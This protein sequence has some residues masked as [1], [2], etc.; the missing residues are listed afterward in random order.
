MARRLLVLTTAL[1]LTGGCGLATVETTSDTEAGKVGIDPTPATD[2]ASPETTSSTS[3]APSLPADLGESVPDDTGAEAPV[4]TTVQ[5]ALSGSTTVGPGEPTTTGAA[6]PSTV[7]PSTTTTIAPSTTSI[8]PSTTTTIALEYHDVGHVVFAYADD[9]P[10]RMPVARYEMVGFHESGH[11][12]AFQLRVADIDDWRTLA[13][14]GRGTG[15]RT[16]ADIVV[17]VGEVVRS[18]VSGNVIRAGTYTLY[19]DHT[20]NFVVIEPEGRPG[21]ELKIF[22][23]EGSAVSVGDVVVAGE[24][25]IGSSGRILPFESQVDEFTSEPSNPH[26]HIEVIDTSIPD[27]PSSGGGC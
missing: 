24:S 19:C 7:S 5:P 18:P 22:H 23:F 9:L 8:A 12:G 3:W 26:V 1:V 16:A 14:R 27:R 17:P 4:S 15:S 25:V 6:T 21:W 10:L 20:D 13:S 11:D 2:P